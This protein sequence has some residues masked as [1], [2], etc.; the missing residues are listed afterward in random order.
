MANGS[1]TGSPKVP[2]QTHH[3]SSKSG[4]F[5]TEDYAKRHPS[6]TERERIKHPKR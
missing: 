6:T 1:K 4:Q 5:V 3:R 2:V